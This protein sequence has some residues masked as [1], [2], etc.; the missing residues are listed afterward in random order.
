MLFPYFYPLFYGLRSI[1]ISWIPS[2]NPSNRKFDYN[3]SMKVL[4]VNHSISLQ[5]FHRI[6]LSK[7]TYD[8]FDRC[9]YIYIYIYLYV[10]LYIYVFFVSIC[11]MWPQ[12]SGPCQD[13]APTVVHG[14]DA[15]AW[16]AYAQDPFNHSHNLTNWLV[17]TF[18]ELF[19]H[20]RNYVF[21]LLK[22]PLWFLAGKLLLL[23]LLL[24]SL[25]GSP[26]LSNTLNTQSAQM[27]RKPLSDPPSSSSSPLSSSY[28]LIFYIYNI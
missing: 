21:L 24:L 2:M 26:H 5:I 28:C 15:C 3:W 17:L 25:A 11:I 6:F 13:A 14:L 22:I 9:L 1:V 16:F 4:H 7:N 8:F 18:H 27:V 19:A 12:K 23:L 10:F 20:F